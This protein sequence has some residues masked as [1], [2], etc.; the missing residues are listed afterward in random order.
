MVAFAELPEPQREHV[1]RYARGALQAADALGRIPT[2]LDD[3]N[4]A[5]KLVTPQEVFDLSDVPPALARRLRRLFGKVRG[6]F[7]VRERVIYLDPELR[8]EQ[9]RFVQG[10]ELGHDALPWHADAYYGEDRR[11]LDPD[12]RDELE[13]EANLFSA[14]LLFN[15]ETFTEQAHA[16]RLGLARPLQLAD[17]FAT[18]RHAALRRYVEAGPRP[19]ALLILGGYPVR[20]D[21]GPALRVPRSL[22]S[23]SFLDRY[24]PISTCLPTTLPLDQWAVARDARAALSGQAVTPVLRGDLTVTDSRKGPVRLDYEVYSNT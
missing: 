8:P 5:L 3:V 22:Q 21:S 20:A 4:E 13:A 2:P 12:T 17:T 18:S 7:A 9:R 19:C 24:G 23:T 6:A 11:T 15:L 10:H 1:A 16:C 14:E